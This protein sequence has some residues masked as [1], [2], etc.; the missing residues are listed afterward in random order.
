MTRDWTEIYKAIELTILAEYGPVK[1]KAKIAK[2]MTPK[3]LTA[4]R[5]AGYMIACREAGK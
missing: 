1:D 5:D 2:D 3:I 4:L